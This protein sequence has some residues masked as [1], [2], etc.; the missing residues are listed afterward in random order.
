MKKLYKNIFLS[1]LYTFFTVLAFCFTFLWL[2][3][4]I[5]QLK[6]Y[7]LL[8]R[9]MFIVSALPALIAGNVLLLF[10]S[11]DQGRRKHFSSASGVYLLLVLSFFYLLTKVFLYPGES[12]SFLIAFMIVCGISLFVNAIFCFLSRRKSVAKDA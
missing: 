4:E 5:E 2:K 10:L 6:G 9:S 12:N 3:L 7:D 8:V 11:R 1:L